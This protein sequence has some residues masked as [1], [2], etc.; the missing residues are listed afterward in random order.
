VAIESDFY[1]RTLQRSHGISNTKAVPDNVLFRSTFALQHIYQP[2]TSP[3]SPI[4]VLGQLKK[5]IN[6]AAAQVINKTGHLEQS[7]DCDCGP[8][9]PPLR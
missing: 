6:S 9:P 3:F 5:N 8:I 1:H 2:V 7:L 4:L